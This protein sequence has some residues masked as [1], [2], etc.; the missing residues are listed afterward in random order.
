MLRLAVRAVPRRPAR[1]AGQ[2]RA[3]A[4]DELARGRPRTG[5]ATP[6]GR[7]AAPTDRRHPEPHRGPARG[8]HRADHG[9]GHHR[10]LR[11]ARVREVA[12]GPQRC[13]RR[14]PAARGAERPPHAHR[15]RHRARRHGD[16]HPG[17]P[18]HRPRD[19]AALS[20]GRL[21]RRR[22][23][24]RGR[25]RAAARRRGGRRRARVAAD[26]RGPRRR[27]RPRTR[28]REGHQPDARRP[29]HARRLGPAGRG[30]VGP[31]PGHLPR[32]RH[33]ARPAA[34][35]LGL[36]ACRRE[37]TQ[38]SAQRRRGPRTLGRRPGGNEARTGACA[39]CPARPAPGARPARGWPAGGRRGAAEP[40][41]CAGA[42]DA[43]DL[44][45]RPGLSLRHVA[46]GR[47]LHGRLRAR[48]RV[49][50][51]RCVDGRR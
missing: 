2:A 10:E 49:A 3:G 51:R 12:A 8:A 50:G 27:T 44:R 30:A 13:R 36:A 32:P 17:G 20:R 35:H 37:K 43:G 29:R 9:R 18:H 28:R 16:R 48:D 7:R 6:R 33:R 1:R 41:H 4:A 46:H 19:G 11:H 23:G 25:A 40:G 34:R 39:P 5:A 31:G 26:R 38:G 47:H 42:G 45:L 21:R 14:H 24:G 15:G 22:A